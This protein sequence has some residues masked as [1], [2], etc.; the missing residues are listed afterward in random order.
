LLS[1]SKGTGFV[2]KNWLRNDGDGRSQAQA[3]QGWQ[4]A[5]DNLNWLHVVGKRAAAD[6]KDCQPDQVV[7]ANVYLQA[8]EKCLI[9]DAA[10]FAALAVWILLHAK[11]ACRCAQLLVLM[12]TG[13]G[14]GNI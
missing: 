6:K 9:L 13:F 5:F 12:V 2:A 10:V 3:A 7:I 4:V 11:G 14:R 8:H 1:K